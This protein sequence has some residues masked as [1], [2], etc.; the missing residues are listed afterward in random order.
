MELLIL[1]GGC[2]GERL[3]GAIPKFIR[4]VRPITVIAAPVLSGSVI[5]HTCR[6]LGAMF[7][8]L[9]CLPGGIGRFIL[10]RTGGI[11]VSCDIF[12]GNKIICV[13][14]WHFGASVQLPSVCQDGLNL[15]GCCGWT[16]SIQDLALRSGA[17]VVRFL[18]A[19][20]GLV[21]SWAGGGITELQVSLLFV[22]H[23]INLGRCFLPRRCGEKTHFFELC[24]RDMAG[25]ERVF[26]LA[27]FAAFFSLRP[28]GR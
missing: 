9:S 13:V 1:C 6:L 12:V 25:R 19:P 24:A 14:G 27:D 7:R 11:S 2:A 17:D 18:E 10:G 4:R 16:G 3:A 5:W 21:P 8:G 20:A 22:N 15:T 23:L 28:C 26:F